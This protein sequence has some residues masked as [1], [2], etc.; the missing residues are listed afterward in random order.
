[1]I[2][3]II[4][5]TANC[6][7]TFDPLAFVAVLNPFKN[8]IKNQIRAM[9]IGTHKSSRTYKSELN[10]FVEFATINVFLIRSDSA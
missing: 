1:M 9:I 7:T 2:S 10:I 3:I 6:A 8:K 4:K 5:V